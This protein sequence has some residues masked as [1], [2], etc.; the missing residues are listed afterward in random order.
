VVDAVTVAAAN[1][2]EVIGQ[3]GEVGE[4]FADLET[5]LSVLMK[6]LDGPE[7]WIPGNFPAGHDGTETL[8]EWFARVL[9]Q[10][11]LG[12]PEIHVAGPAMHEEIDHTLGPA[13][14]V[15]RLWGER[16]LRGGSISLPGREEMGQGQAADATAGMEEKLASA[17]GWWHRRFLAL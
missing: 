10:I 8:R 12:I 16:T 9:L 1:D 14:K 7:E 11:G 13:G 2:T 15:G 17:G 6:G 4:K 3:P 5:G